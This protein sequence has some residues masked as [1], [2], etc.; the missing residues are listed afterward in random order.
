MWYATS[1]IYVNKA[2]YFATNEDPNIKLGP[3]KVPGAGSM[4]ASITRASETQPINTG[5]PNPI[6]VNLICERDQL[7]KD[8]CLMVGDSLFT[9]ILFANNAEIDGL[10]VLS[11]VTNQEDFERYSKEPGMGI[12]N[13]YAEDLKL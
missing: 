6:T 3:Y 1:C 10:L 9:D 11:G 8:K 5:K 12:P 7:D 2:I 13:Y 4:T